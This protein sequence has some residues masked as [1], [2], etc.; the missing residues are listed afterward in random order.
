MEKC[1]VISFKTVGIALILLSSAFVVFGTNTGTAAEDPLVPGIPTGL[2][3]VPGYEQ[4]S[5]NWTAPVFDGGSAIDYY[6]IFQDGIELPDHF[7]VF[8]TNIIGLNVSKYSSQT[9]SFTVAAHNAAGTGPQCDLVTATPYTTP[10]SII[11]LSILPGDGNVSFSWWTPDGKGGS[12]ILY[13][14]ILLEGIVVEHTLNRWAGINGLTNGQSYNFSIVAHNAAGGGDYANF[15]AIPLTT[16]GPPIGLSATPGNGQV[17][18]TWKSSSNYGELGIGGYYVYQDGVKVATA[19]ETSISVTGLTNGQTYNFSL[20]SRYYGHRQTQGASQE[21]ESPRSFG[22][23]ATPRPETAGIPTGLTAT[24]GDGKVDMS[25]LTPDNGGATIDYYIV[26]QNSIDVKHVTGNS[27]TIIGLANGQS[28]SF[29]IA[30]HNIAGIS[31]Q[32]SAIEAMP[33]TVPD[34]PTGYAAI[35]GNGLVTLNWAAPTF[36]GGR[37]I[38]YYIMFQDG[39]ALPYHLTGPSTIIAGLVNGQTYSF[40]VSA[41]NIAG[42]G[43]QSMAMPSVPYTLSDAPTGL[44]AVLG[45]TQVILTWAAP[46]YDGGSVIDYYVVYQDGIALPDRLTGLTEEI[47]SLIN[48]QNYSFTVSAHNAAGLGARSSAVT[49]TLFTVPLA[50][51]SLTAIAGNENVTLSWTSPIDLHGLPLNGYSIYRGLSNDS[52]MIIVDNKTSLSYTDKGLT[53]GLTYLYKVI[54]INS[55]GDGPASTCSVKPVGIAPPIGYIQGISGDTSVILSWQTPVTNGGYPLTSFKIYRSESGNASGLIA[56]VGPHV[57]NYVDDT[58]IR[59]IP[60]SY[61]VVAINQYGDSRP[62]ITTS[63]IH[64]YSLAKIETSGD[65]TTTNLGYTIK[66][67][68]HVSQVKDDLSILGLNVVFQYSVTAGST[69]NEISSGVSDPNG[70]CTIDWIP[71]ATGNFTIKASW[72]GNDE[73]LPVVSTMNLAV[74]SSDKHYFTVQSNSTIANLAFDPVSKEMSFTVSG[75]SGRSGYTTIIVSKGLVAN[76]SDIR[77]SLNGA[78]MSYALSSTDSYWILYFTYQHSTH[79]IVATLSEGS[80]AAGPNDTTNDSSLPLFAIAGIAVIAVLLV[81][82]LVVVSKRRNKK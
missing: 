76:G 68:A 22:V 4:V 58:A 33:Y 49:A 27:S 43:S 9:Y 39:V 64:V 45:N 24:L 74:S 17:F 60:Y 13:Y 31:A 35:P 32:S 12:Q 67:T 38:D 29:T 48:G 77:I 71:A 70:N 61:F 7:K 19:W 54:A 79:S 57:L 72:V 51:T 62:S 36:D 47:F 2:T 6:I 5:L 63:Q 75:I 20:T 56:S 41:H 53:N 42:I 3:A 10:S 14:V 28:Y 52:M 81:V 21:E 30:A 15:T 80:V 78:N 37:A 11:H 44:T 59:G 23:L 25:W 40:T 16:P 69:W 34:A 8:A 55:V 26:Y 46:G 66:L 50:P 1:S 73:Y 65:M 18:L 82:G